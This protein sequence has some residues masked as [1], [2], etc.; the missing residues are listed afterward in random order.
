MVI[1]VL[2]PSEWGASAAILG[3]GQFLGAACS[4]GSQVERIKRYSR[5]EAEA[6]AETA[7]GDT[8]ARL[9][10]AFLIAL[11]ALVVSPFAAAPAAGLIAASGVFASL[12][13]T[14]HLIARRRYAAA[15]VVQVSEKGA[16][17]VV[18]ILVAWSGTLVSVSL[19]I[20]VGVSGLAASVMVFALLTP[21]RRSITVGIR[22]QSILQI[23]KG[24]LYL[25]IA[26]LAPAALLLDVT[27]VLA[28]AGA[29]EA[30]LFAVAT[31]L[32]APL[33]IAATAVVAVLLPELSSSSSRALPRPGRKGIVALVMT[34]LG[35]A[36]VFLTA[37]YWVPLI[38]GEE[39]RGA[40]WPVRFYVLNVVVILGTRALV[41]ML[42]A[43][44]DERAASFLV[45]AQVA[46]ALIGIAVGAHFA[47]AFG[48]SIAVLATNVLLAVALWLR[49][50]RVAEGP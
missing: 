29:V 28:I 1:A 33:S 26:S 35:L 19:A 43:W 23:W 31:K 21:S 20:I 37:S 45:A 39:Y 7:R 32:T 41:T 36:L 14:N 6:V 46:T 38:F 49:V 30:G 42:Q 50:M 48:A 40:V 47:G 3:A 10:V 16:A 12:G 24:S 44:N 27:V 13:A 22:P 5:L 8:A 17:L 15:G 11:V 34:L 2:A 9:T 18:V 4:F 25:G